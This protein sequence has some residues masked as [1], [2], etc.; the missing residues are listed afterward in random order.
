MSTLNALLDRSAQEGGGKT[1]LVFGDREVSFLDLRRQVLEIA[2]GLRR[3]VVVEYTVPV[4]SGSTQ[5]S[6]APPQ[7]GHTTR[8]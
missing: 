4:P 7:C 1:A 6:D 8:G 5:A 2:E 3:T